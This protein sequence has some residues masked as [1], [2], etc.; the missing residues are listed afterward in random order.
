MHQNEDYTDRW[1]DRHKTFL[2]QL[3]KSA[4]EQKALRE[5]LA[6]KGYGT[7]PGMKKG[8]KVQFYK[9]ARPLTL[10][11]DVMCDA[12]N[13]HCHY[14]A[15]DEDTETFYAAWALRPYKEGM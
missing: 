11:C 8:D 2:A 6:T 4:E 15:V 1:S 9:E 3:E 10:S 5:K 12:T 7:I 14:L 13:V